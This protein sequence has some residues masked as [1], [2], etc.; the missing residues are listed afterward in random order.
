[1]SEAH[2]DVATLDI[3]EHLRTPEEIAAFIEAAIEL[4]DYPTLLRALAHA[5][6]AQGMA[7]V[8]ERSGLGRESLYKALAPDSKPR[9]ETVARVM[10][11]LNL[12]VSIT[13]NVAGSV[14]A[15]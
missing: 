13:A 2:H 11:A 7:E 3:A 5:A 12:T 1:M 14:E 6:R 4:G 10:K 8:A 9:F 15:A